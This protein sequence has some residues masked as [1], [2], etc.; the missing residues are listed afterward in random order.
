MIG[1]N[2]HWIYAHL[3][4]DYLFQNDWMA[5]NKKKNSVICLVHVFAYMTPFIFTQLNEIQLLLIAGQHY[6][7]DRTNFVAWFCKKTNKFQ[8]DYSKF[9]GHVIIDN[10][11]HILWMAT[12]ANYFA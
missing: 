3:I 5:E 8:N 12:V 11:I 7:Q 10:V 9:F 6:A 1:F 4:G 2:L